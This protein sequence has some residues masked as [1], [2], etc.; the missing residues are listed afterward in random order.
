[1]TA[2]S[3]S[4][5]ETTCNLTLA[6]APALRGF[7]LGMSAKEFKAR[8]PSV[9]VREIDEVGGAKAEIFSN[10]SASKI[11]KAELKDVESITLLFADDRLESI[12]V[13][14]TN[15][16]KWESAD[17]F[18]STISKA[19]NLPGTWKSVEWWQESLQCDG[20]RATAGAGVITFIKLEALID[21]RSREERLK[22]IAD[23]RKALQKEKEEKKKREAEARRSAF[24]P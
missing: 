19:L 2:V 9:E 10:D 8:Y 3:V 16:I 13:R 12:S 14:Y 1:M 22:A 21:Q 24:K 7:R 4:A 18:V 11:D 17:Q 6:Q 5:Q 15:I 23:Q 20:F